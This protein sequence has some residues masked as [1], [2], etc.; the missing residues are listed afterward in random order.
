[1]TYCGELPYEHRGAIT[2]TLYVWTARKTT[3]WVDKR[4]LPALLKAAGA[5]NLE[6]DWV[7][8]VKERKAEQTRKRAEKREAKRKTE[9]VSG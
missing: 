9:E 8:E 1:V 5:D 2:D 3:E 6:S 4:D 7:N